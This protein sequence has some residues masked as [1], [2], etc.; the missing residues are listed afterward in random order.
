MLHRH[1][2]VSPEDIKEIIWLFQYEGLT[3]TEIA[4][5]KDIHFTTLVKFFKREG[6]K[7]INPKKKKNCHD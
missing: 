6:I 5:R 7:R 2:P 3:I 1:T 4:G